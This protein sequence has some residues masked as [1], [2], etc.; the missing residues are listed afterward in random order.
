L[1]WGYEVCCLSKDDETRQ[2]RY[3]EMVAKGE[4]WGS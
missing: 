1:R 2:A 3:E 4:V